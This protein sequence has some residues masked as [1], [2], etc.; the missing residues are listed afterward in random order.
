MGKTQNKK[1]PKQFP[2]PCSS[3]NTV[4]QQR[5]MDFRETAVLEKRFSSNFISFISKVLEIIM[6]PRYFYVG[7]LKS[8][9][10][11]SSLSTFSTLDGRPLLKELSNFSHCRELGMYREIVLGSKVVINHHLRFL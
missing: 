3:N 11:Q 7:A 9:C 2:D 6:N 4:R 10:K 5:S 8:V 1:A